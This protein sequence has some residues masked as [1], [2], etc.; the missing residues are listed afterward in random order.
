MAA[1]VPKVAEDRDRNQPVTFSG[2]FWAKLRNPREDGTLTATNPS[3][4]RW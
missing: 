4:S 1:Y 2:G 3:T